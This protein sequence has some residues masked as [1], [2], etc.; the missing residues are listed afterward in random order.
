M[1]VCQ[2]AE[3][4]PYHSLGQLLSSLNFYASLWTTC[5]AYCYAPSCKAWHGSYQ[6][7]SSAQIVLAPAPSATASVSSSGRLQ[8]WVLH[9][10]QAVQQP[11]RGVIEQPLIA[12]A[13]PAGL[14]PGRPAGATD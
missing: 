1:G 3:A 6:H 4:S 13:Q 12:I 2:L 9:Q 11:L 14:G 5:P 8:V 10:L 7:E